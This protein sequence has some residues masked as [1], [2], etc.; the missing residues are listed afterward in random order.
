MSATIPPK[1]K[2]SEG[3]SKKNWSFE[4]RSFRE[5]LGVPAILVSVIVR[6]PSVA[7]PRSITAAANARCAA[8]FAPD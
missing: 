6:R 4:A 7:C 3:Q 2:T 5:S 8:A 1:Q